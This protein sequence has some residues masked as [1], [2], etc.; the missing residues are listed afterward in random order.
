MSAASKSETVWFR[1]KATGRVEGVNKGTPAYKRMLSEMTGGDEPELVW[2]K[3]SRPKGKPT[4]YVAGSGP[5]FVAS[6]YDHEAEAAK[7]KPSGDQGQGSGDGG[8]GKGSGD[9]K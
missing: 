1:N 4:K 7:V 9:G 3:T 5:T 6:R 8:D 2:A